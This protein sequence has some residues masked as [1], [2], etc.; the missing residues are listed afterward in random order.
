VFG[1]ID[2][3]TT[4][5]GARAVRTGIQA[6]KISLIVTK[7][8]TCGSIR[9]YWNGALIKSWSLT[10][11]TTLRKQV[12]NAASFSTVQS[13]TLTIVVTS[14]GKKVILEGLAVSRV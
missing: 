8:A 10:S 4:T 12:L 11:A 1:G 6:K 5:Y 14:A 7:C 13:G 2:E 3:Y 9:V